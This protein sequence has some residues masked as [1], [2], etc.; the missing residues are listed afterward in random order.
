MKT[1]LEFRRILATMM[2]SRLGELGVAQS[3]FERCAG[4]AH[5]TFQNI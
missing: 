3:T 2:V 5:N 4:M 1:D